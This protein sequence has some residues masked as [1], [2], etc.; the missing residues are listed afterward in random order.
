MAKMCTKCGVCSKAPGKQRCYEC[1]L[2][3]LPPFEQE[4]DAE[5]RRGCVPVEMHRARVP[6]AQWP[7]GRRWCSG[8]QSF[9]RLE[10]CSG[11]R[12]RTCAGL[13]AW[14]AMLP[15]T[16]KIQT[17]SGTIRP[18]TADDYRLLY[19]ACGGRCP[20]CNRRVLSKRMAVDHDHTTGLVRGLLDPSDEFGCNRA[21]L[22]N[23]RDLPMARR[24]VGYL[25]APPAS[26]LIPE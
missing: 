19:A 7:A 20:I 6:E 9:R 5:R 15:R 1:L 12:C 11:S 22:G 2:L 16:Y 10:D 26:R 25:E 4:L 24:I 21:V 18:F 13:A 23:I 3:E 17:A 14:E 8:C